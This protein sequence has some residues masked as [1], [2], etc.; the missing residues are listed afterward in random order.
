MID[1]SRTFGVDETE[2]AAS[3]ILER[4]NK[5]GDRVADIAMFAADRYILNGFS[6]LIASSF[7]QPYCGEPNQGGQTLRGCWY[8]SDQFFR[9]ITEVHP[10]A[11][12]WAGEPWYQQEKLLMRYMELMNEYGVESIEAECFAAEHGDD[13]T[14]SRLFRM[15]KRIK[16]SLQ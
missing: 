12:T 4:Y 1:L 8:A 6:E 7:L 2:R 9:R 11:I 14:V 16:Q 3:I 15:S 5:C 13:E 10:E